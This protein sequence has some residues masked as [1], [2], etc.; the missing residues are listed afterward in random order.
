M[1][2]PLDK[3]CTCSVVN[4]QSRAGQMVG[5]SPFDGKPI[6]YSQEFIDKMKSP[7]QTVHE[8]SDWVSN[9]VR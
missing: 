6:K 5:V 1:V 7:T 3:C 9:F 2:V 8:I 4:V